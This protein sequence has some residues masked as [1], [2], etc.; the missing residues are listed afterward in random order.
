MRKNLKFSVGSLLFF[1]CD[2]NLYFV[3]FLSLLFWNNY[4]SKEVGKIVQRSYAPFTQLAP[5]VTTYVTVTWFQN[6][7]LDTGIVCVWGCHF[8]TCIDSLNP[9]SQHMCISIITKVP[10]LLPPYSHTGILVPQLTSSPQHQWSW[11]SSPSL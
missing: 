5:M 3:T 7:D 6:G 4:N 9:Y 2:F 11:I 8:I 10:L 1:N